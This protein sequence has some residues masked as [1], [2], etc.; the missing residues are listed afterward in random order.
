M[1]LL[2]EVMLTPAKAFRC[3]PDGPLYF[4]RAPESLQLTVRHFSELFETRR[5]V[6]PT[7]SASKTPGEQE[8]NYV[9]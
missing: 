5:A 3:G 7:D 2:G 4:Q 6:T 8:H 1:L 9:I